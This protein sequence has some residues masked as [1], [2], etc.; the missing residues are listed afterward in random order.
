M[1]YLVVEQVWSA[2]IGN[3]KCAYT[4]FKAIL[5][6]VRRIENIVND[7]LRRVGYGAVTWR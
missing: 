6:K 4:F 7:V 5:I 1:K 2:C 3:K